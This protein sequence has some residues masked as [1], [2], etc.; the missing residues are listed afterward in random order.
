MLGKILG[1]LMNRLAMT[2]VGISLL[3]GLIWFGSEYVGLEDYRFWILA[4]IAIAVALLLLVRRFLIG[5][6][7]RQMEESLRSQGE[8]QREN[9]LPSE[10]GEIDA[11]EKQFEDALV[12]LKKSKGG[13][14]ALYAFPW[15]VIIGPPGS[16]KSTLINESNLNLPYMKH[17]RGEIRGV[18]G[19]R[20]CD[21]F[22]TDQAILLDTAGR[23]MTEM[24]D[25]E[26]WLSFL[27]MLEQGRKRQPING[28]IIAISIPEIIAASETELDKHAE[29]IRNRLDEL[30]KNL[31]TICPVYLIF[32]KCD[33]LDGFVEFFGGFSKDD[34]AQVWGCTVDPDPSGQKSFADAFDDGFTGLFDRVCGERI[35]QLS[36]DRPAGKRQKIHA[37]PLQFALAR[38]RLGQLVDAI[39]QPNPYQETAF[40]R[41]FYFSSGTQEG[42]PIDVVTERVGKAMGIASASTS[43]SAETQKRCYF[44]N[45]LFSK[46]MFPDQ[47]LA[48]R[49]AKIEKRRRLG[50][51][52]SMRGSV[53]AASLFLVAMTYSA[54]GSC[55]E[56]SD[57]NGV[58]NRFK[59]GELADNDATVLSALHSMSRHI[60]SLKTPSINI[61][62]NRIRQLRRRALGHYLPRFKSSFIVPTSNALE[63]E[64]NKTIKKWKKELQ[65][66][67]ERGEKYAPSKDEESLFRRRLAVYQSISGSATTV[68]SDQLKVVLA[69]SAIW[70]FRKKLERS[71]RTTDRDSESDGQPRENLTNGEKIDRQREFLVNV[72]APNQRLRKDWICDSATRTTVK[73]DADAILKEVNI[74]YGLYSKVVAGMQAA[75][76][77]LDDLLKAKPHMAD[78]FNSTQKISS[79]FFK[80]ASS[81]FN[82]LRSEAVRDH[83]AELQ[84]TGNTA[85]KTLVGDLT[86]GVDEEYSRNS[87]AAWETFLSG[88]EP[89]GFVSVKSAK[90]RLTVL[91]EKDK[92]PY[93]TLYEAIENAMPGMTPGQAK[94]AEPL[95][96]VD[97]LRADIAKNL[98]GELTLEGFQPQQLQNF[99]DKL[100]HTQETR[101]RL[102]RDL[103]PPYRK[104][105]ETLL[106][107]IWFKTRE[108]VK[109]DLGS[110]L[111][112][113]W[114]NLKDRLA[115]DHFPIKPGATAKEIT[116]RQLAPFV[117]TTGDLAK[118]FGVVKVIENAAGVSVDSKFD[119]FRI[120]VE[121]VQKTLFDV[122]PKTKDWR[123]R[124]T[125]KFATGADIVDIR[126]SQGDEEQDWQYTDNV[127]Y[128]SDWKLEQGPLTVKCDT[129][130]G[131]VP[132]D[133]PSLKSESWGLFRFIQAGHP[134]AEGKDVKCTWT[135]LGAEA[136]YG[137][138][139][140]VSVDSDDNPFT[141]DFFN[142]IATL[143]DRV[144]SKPQ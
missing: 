75:D 102:T 77:S 74:A 1:L 27:R 80:D 35:V 87:S 26:E 43:S 137:I 58:V 66:H 126:I 119:A 20:N 49:T 138:S 111:N 19:T 120:A 134:Q 23:Y 24:E 31:N 113:E 103:K 36:P 82:R 47:N 139:A 46:V 48:R 45:D 136:K 121:A 128:S 89:N 84:R 65:A 6:S 33:L 37:F 5:R 29:N 53:V 12:A 51:V 62:L 133:L 90:E 72:I 85:E 60:Q 135:F 88:I 21:W 44:I 69:D 61:G 10:Q 4:G 2:I 92:S 94:L 91:A 97:E 17:G 131:L 63:T 79:V 8:E 129:G 93:L 13:R 39:A 71:E 144:C 110:K 76:R 143:P 18:G 142:Q 105:V 123:L 112:K 127:P 116:K 59:V 124:V 42:Q 73:S 125:M 141:P 96:Q 107:K 9:V 57:S 95:A 7:A 117:P 70:T 115:V 106:A 114:L 108:A 83:V 55:S 56:I 104:V 130:S 78:H 118:F 86:R 101:D 67:K 28:I 99:F 68:T 52:L 64:I 41:G 34:R 81:T 11:L 50:R 100:E 38:Q 14:G 140:V 3:V 32:T 30:T 22:F 98:K 15:Y 54:F 40:F 132:V 16:G 25:R 122:D 109:A